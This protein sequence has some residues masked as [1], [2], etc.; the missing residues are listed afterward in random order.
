MIMQ[1]ILLKLD[2]VNTQRVPE[3][4]SKRRKLM[5]IFRDAPKILDAIARGQTKPLRPL[6]TT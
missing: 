1:D 2:G 5:R 4:R 3:A 6:S